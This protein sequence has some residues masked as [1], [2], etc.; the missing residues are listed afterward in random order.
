MQPKSIWQ[1]FPQFVSKCSQ[2]HECYNQLQEDVAKD[3]LIATEKE[4]EKRTI[5]KVYFIVEKTLNS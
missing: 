2:N 4:S 5:L 3:I 1:Q